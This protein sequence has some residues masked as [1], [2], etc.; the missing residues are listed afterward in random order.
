MKIYIFDSYGL[1]SLAMVY[2]NRDRDHDLYKSFHTKLPISA[3]FITSSANIQGAYVLISKIQ[4]R[5]L[6][7]EMSRI[8]TFFIQGRFRGHEIENLDDNKILKKY[9]AFVIKNNDFKVWR[10]TTAFISTEIYKSAEIIGKS[11]SLYQK[12]NIPM[13]YSC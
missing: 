10:N 5:H 3:K 9:G 4:D 12:L 7:S 6:L 1:V 11:C 2:H 13:A 8:I